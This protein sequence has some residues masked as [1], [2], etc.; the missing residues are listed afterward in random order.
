LTHNP[1]F[2][3]CEF[4][5]AYSNLD[6]LIK[7]T[8]SLF[9][10]LASK[11]ADTISK[12][13]TTLDQPAID[14]AGPFPRIDFIPAVEEATGHKLPDLRAPTARSEVALLVAACG[15]TV[16]TQASLPQMLDRL[17]ATYLE[18]RC[19]GPTLITHQPECLSPLAKSFAHAGAG[20]QRVA[21]RAE[22]FVH[23]HELANM[24]EEEN[25]PAEQRRKFGEQQLMRD[26]DGDD[27][28]SGIDEGYLEALAWGLPPTGGWGCGIDR[29]AMV[30]SGAGRIGDV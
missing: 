20:G 21:A 3:T 6:E 10:G 9:H 13:L 29:L 28:D 12:K 2:T 16:P 23:G 14:F 25:S 26:R 1:E 27:D 24:Y 8:E 18:P 7:L 11:V 5:R 15:I 17:S 19:S 30:M 4:Y 22:L